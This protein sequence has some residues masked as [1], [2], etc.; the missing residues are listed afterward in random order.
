[1]FLRV[2]ARRLRVPNDRRNGRSVTAPDDARQ[3]KD[4]L[5]T[6]AAD[7]AAT[8]SV[9]PLEAVGSVE[10]VDSSWARPVDPVLRL[11][12][13]ALPADLPFLRDLL[14]AVPT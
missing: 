5:V 8:H 9:S 11:A 6:A 12:V 4:E 7:A 2:E 13:L 14:P 10:R 3:A 1:M